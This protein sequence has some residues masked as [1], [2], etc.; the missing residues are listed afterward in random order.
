MV[1]PTVLYGP[2]TNPQAFESYYAE[3]HM[4]IA[5]RIPN[6]ERFESGRVLGVPDGGDPPY[7]RFAELWFADVERLQTSMA[8]AEGRA[9]VDDIPKFA[10]GGATVFFSELD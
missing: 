3:R 9:A 4:P 8:S 2:P 5:A 10:T 6:V 7:H 1:K